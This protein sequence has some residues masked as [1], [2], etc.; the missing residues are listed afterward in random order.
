[1]TINSR[2]LHQQ[3]LAVLAVFAGGIVGTSARYALESMFPASAGH[4][5]WTTFGINIAGA[6]L[7]G[8]IAA[9]LVA[10][11]DDSPRRQ[12]IRLFA[13]TGCCGAF[14]T[15]ST[16]ALEQTNLWRHDAGGIA[17]GY[18]VVS[19]VAGV[20]AAWTGFLLGDKLTGGGLR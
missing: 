20:L 6:A 7:L 8:I 14:T 16:F 5:P 3:P 19:V 17:L 2:P 4:W 10:R 9:V 13:G 12:R 1:M 18:A 11:A 15:Y